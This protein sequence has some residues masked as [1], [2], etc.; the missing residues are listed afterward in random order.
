[1]NLNPQI[2][3]K[4][5][6][7][8]NEFNDFI[9]LYKTKQLPNKI[10]LSGQ[11]GVGKC[12]LGYH[13]I[14]YILSIDEEYSY[15]LDE[16]SIFEE[17]K[18]F[19]LIQNKSNPNFSLIDVLDEKKKIEISQI[20]NLI[21]NI[22][23]TSFNS[24]PRF[25]L[26]D[27]IENLNPNSINAL[28]KIIEEPVANCFFIL[29]HNNHKILETLKSRCINF[30]ISL[31]NKSSILVSNKLVNDNIENLI[32]KDF[33]DYYITPGKIYNLIKFS[34]ENKI[35]LKYMSLKDLLNLI[36]DENLY[37]KETTFK[38]MIYELIELFMVKKFSLHNAEFIDYF[39]KKIN[40]LKKYNLD[41]KSLFFEFKKELLDG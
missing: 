27:N 38:N 31:S 4:L 41:E 35:D 40:N 39:L 12:T 7:L 6:G 37:K 13:I 1:M 8:N 26:I 25:V 23:K 11:K 9:K 10:L 24:K 32:N 5:Y 36:I 21:T 15:N 18:S 28:L 3:T 30:K 20:R 29:I 34:K 22:N 33:L 14:N 17:N 16:C 19:K 2:Q